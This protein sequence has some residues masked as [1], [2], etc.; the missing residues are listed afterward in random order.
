M[1]KTNLKKY[2]IG[3][4]QA[5]TRGTY[6]KNITHTHTHTHTHIHKF[7]CTHTHLHVSG[8]RKHTT[9]AEGECC[10]LYASKGG[11]V[12]EAPQGVSGCGRGRG[13]VGRAPPPTVNEIKFKKNNKNKNYES[14]KKNQI[15]IK[16]TNCEFRAKIVMP[17]IKKTIHDQQWPKNFHPRLG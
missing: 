8:P 4:T 15:K 5:E 16:I 17:S 13:L 11:L 6:N 7:T 12:G 1:P 9:R 10:T 2:V 14:G 3:V